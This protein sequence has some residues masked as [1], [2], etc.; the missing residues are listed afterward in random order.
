MLYQDSKNLASIILKGFKEG[1]GF[2]L[3]AKA[4]VLKEALV[5]IRSSSEEEKQEMIK[6]L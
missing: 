2:S 3:A 1:R 6:S 4:K 5:I